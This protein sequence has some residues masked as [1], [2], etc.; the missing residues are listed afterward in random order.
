MSERDPLPT[1]EPVAE[2]PL[3]ASQTRCWIV[4]RAS[5]GTETLN[6]AVRWEI[7]GPLR[8]DDLEAAFRKVIARHEI[9]R[10]SFQDGEDGPVQRVHAEAPFQ[11]SL[12]DLRRVPEP[13]QM[14]R[15]DDIA[16]ETAAR[17]F[18][19]SRPGLLRAT[20]VRLT[21]ERAILC[22]TA[23]HIVFDGASIGVLGREVGAALEGRALPEPELHYGDYV[24]WERAAQAEAGSADLDW[25]RQT[26]DGVPY[27]ELEADRPRSPRRDTAVGRVALDLP[28]GFGTRLGAAARAAGVSP[29]AFGAA[30]FSAVLHRA[31]G[32]RDIALGTPVAGRLEA[33]LD[34][35]IGVFINWLV[36]RLRPEPGLTLA[37]HATATGRTVEAAL[38]HQ[39]TPFERVVEAVNPPRDPA[40]TPLV[41]TN[42]S[43]QRVFME[44]RTYAGLG[45]RS[46]ASH[47]PGTLH[48]LDLSVMERPGGW[49]I[50]L[51]YAAALFTHETAE[52]LTRAT[53]DAFAQA[54]DAPETPISALPAL[55]RAARPGGAPEV[56][57]AEATLAA[58]RLVGE[59]V[60]IDGPSG[61]WAF[62][63]PGA[64][65]LLPLDALPETLRADL[66][67]L[68][69][70]GVS[71][72][73]ALPRTATGTVDRSM[74]R[75]PAEAANADLQ[76]ET[77]A[78]LARDW[79]ELLRV[80][81]DGA[82]HFFD[83]GGHSLLVM[84]LLARVRDRWGVPLD[85][86]DVYEAP[87]LR[88]LA[89]R[90]ATARSGRRAPGAVPGLLRI[91][92]DGPN[93]PLVI[94]N[95]RATATALSTLPGQDRPIGCV[96]A[97][98]PG[99]GIGDASFEEVARGFA[100]RIR[101]YQP[102]GP[103]FLYGHCVH[104]NLALEAAR[105]LA[106]D[107]AEITGVAMKEV[108]AP[109]FAAEVAAD[110]GLRRQNRLHHLR[111]RLRAVRTGEMSPTAFLRSYSI[112]HRTGVVRALAA[113]GLMEHGRLTD[114]EAD[115]ERFVVELCRAR[116]VYRPGPVDF[117]VLHVV[118]R[119][120]PRG[121]RWK[122]SIGWE[123]VV[124][125]KL[126]RTVHLPW[127]SV[128]EGRREG[129]DA[130]GAELTRFCEDARAGRPM[131]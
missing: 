95:N 62:V 90:I 116:D 118:T 5:P 17:P 123:D 26:L 86:T 108:W 100:D 21:G 84:R 114:L 54:F 27:F 104:G 50:V 35:L 87:R 31:T 45:F 70:A 30:V 24:L 49:Q 11:L 75:A 78:E 68:G 89:T 106:A 117:P 120:T 67:G 36:L 57:P 28:E 2:F 63:T 85:L 51:E 109:A 8:E 112:F 19:L 10:T 40:R 129:V 34:P 130:F 99:A 56:A 91:R 73:A 125:P 96:V 16:R 60:L 122:P 4:D 7:T 66:P 98:D 102:Q 48:D 76:A 115:F 110:A 88:D 18:D 69:L 94:V 119:A 124:P 72:L 33:E 9:L 97:A 65:G 92:S 14:A 128:G 121:P 74:L 131:A 3:S 127:V 46:V 52:A 59:A 39:Q 41:S 20:L 111:L 42:F 113:S 1:P 58:H 71:V 126:L 23:H 61:P 38:I 55:V 77:E 79:A 107:G 22:L 12:V 101:L 64:V 82:S 47:A 81:V 15:L 6:I 105:H 93:H 44:S 53:A 37:Q 29:F 32:A 80:E 43:L 103:Y 25:W 83:L 13:D